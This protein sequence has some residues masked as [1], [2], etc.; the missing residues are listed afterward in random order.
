MPLLLEPN[1]GCRFHSDLLHAGVVPFSRHACVL[2]REKFFP[3]G[4]DSITRDLINA[5]IK[6]PVEAFCNELFSHHKYGCAEV[7]FIVYFFKII[8]LFV[9]LLYFFN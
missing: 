7:E 2:N 1:S 4:N 6:F 3:G 5:L 8:S 9:G